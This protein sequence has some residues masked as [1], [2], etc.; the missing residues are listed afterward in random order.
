[1]FS[2]VKTM[3]CKI[4]LLVERGERMKGSMYW[5]E[6]LTFFYSYQE[7]LPKCLVRNI[8]QSLPKSGLVLAFE[9]Q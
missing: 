6:G 5:E 1:M 4:Y 2:P 9:G 7:H 8:N 3:W